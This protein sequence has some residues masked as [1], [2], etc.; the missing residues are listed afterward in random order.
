MDRTA[1]I[2]APGKDDL[3][4]RRYSHLYRILIASNTWLLIAM[5][6]VYATMNDV[7]I[8]LDGQCQCPVALFCFVWNRKMEQGSVHRASGV[9]PCAVCRLSRCF[10]QG[11]PETPA[12][13]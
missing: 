10:G 11:M 4:G 2:Y 13:I 3:L 9:P 8:D 5:P 7:E 6:L 1:I 12:E